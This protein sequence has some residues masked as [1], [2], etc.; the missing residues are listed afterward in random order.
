M[1]CVIALGLGVFALGCAKPLPVV[2]AP[3]ANDAQAVLEPARPIEASADPT[4]CAGA[5]RNLARLGCPEGLRGNCEA[6]CRH[7]QEIT[8]FKTA[9]LT[10]AGSV[11]AARRCG[12]L[13]PDGG[14]IQ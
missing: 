7:G 5:C 2:P 11:E 12:T 14:C 6:S 13:G 1:R 8:D 3:D 10:Q 4:G 9:C